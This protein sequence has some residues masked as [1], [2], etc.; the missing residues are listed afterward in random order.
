MSYSVWCLLVVSTV[1][2]KHWYHYILPFCSSG[3]ADV[4]SSFHQK[5]NRK[6][7]DEEN[8][9]NDCLIS[10]WGMLYFWRILLKEYRIGY[11][12]TSVISYY[13]ILWYEIHVMI[14]LLRCNACMACDG[15]PEDSD[16][17]GWSNY[18]LTYSGSTVNRLI[19]SIKVPQFIFS[20][21]LPAAI[22]AFQTGKLIVTSKQLLQLIGHV[23]GLRGSQWQVFCIL[24]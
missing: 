10:C 13:F 21:V 8:W 15:L 1:N 18:V 9:R 2:I 22:L 12:N 3:V 14:V 6:K 4:V 7:S 19:A 20:F 23:S 11:Q 16:W 24:H 17:N 5:T